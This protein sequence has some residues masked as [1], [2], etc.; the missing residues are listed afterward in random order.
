M[1][2]IKYQL[3]CLVLFSFVSCVQST[4]STKKDTANS[5]ITEYIKKTSSL[6]DYSQII[7]TFDC[8]YDNAIQSHREYYN[9]TDS[10]IGLDSLI[11]FNERVDSALI[12]YVIKVKNYTDS[13]YH[14]RTPHLFCYK[15]LGRWR[16]YD[17]CAS[18]AYSSE[19]YTLQMVKMN[20]R[21][22]SVFDLHWLYFQE[23]YR[24]EINRNFLKEANRN[25]CGICLQ[26]EEKQTPDECEQILKKQTPPDSLYLCK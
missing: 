18:A 16:F 26:E 15:Q 20:E 19:I 17:G 1:P 24:V 5:F 25:V 22:V 11:I 8:F 10:L 21:L 13:N 14:Y 12:F 4:T 7:R 3:F 2:I 23:N 6:P 9:N